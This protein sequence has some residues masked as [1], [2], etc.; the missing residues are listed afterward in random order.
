MFSEI[1]YHDFMAIHYSKNTIRSIH[2]FCA[3][4]IY[5]GKCEDRTC[6]RI[7]SSNLDYMRMYLGNDKIKSEYC[8]RE[9]DC[10]YFLCI[11]R[12]KYDHIILGTSD[13]NNET[14]FHLP[15]EERNKAKNDWYKSKSIVK[16][17][18]IRMIDKTNN[19][20]NIK[21]NIENDINNC[22]KNITDESEKLKK[23]ICNINEYKNEN[24][25]VIKYKYK[26]K[27]YNEPIQKKVKKNLKTFKQ[28]KNID[29][30]FMDTKTIW[31][32]L[33]DEE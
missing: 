14:M 10:K 18:Q 6:D 15:E 12:H 23:I 2:D 27:E 31:Y 25:K 20:T 26:L 21:T 17:K 3:F 8:E 32:N 7:H 28:T 29:T 1:S 9:S 22:L 13:S 30:N 5:S 24:E 4:H 16:N 33:M 19:E 11:F